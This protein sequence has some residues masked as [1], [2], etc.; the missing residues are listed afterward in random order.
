MDLHKHTCVGLR[1]KLEK[2][3]TQR[4]IELKNKHQNEKHTLTLRNMILQSKVEDMK[5][6]IKDQEEEIF[7]LMLPD[8]C[9]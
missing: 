7:T 2:E 9:L 8:V 6:K 5:K 3:N 4:I 1:A